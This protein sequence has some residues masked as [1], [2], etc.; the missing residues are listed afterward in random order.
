MCLRK[1]KEKKCKSL[2][3]FR[4]ANKSDNYQRGEEKEKNRKKSKRIYRTNQNIIHVFLE[5]VPSE[6]FYLLE[7]TVHLTCLGCS[8]TLY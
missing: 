4:S 6:S 5:S 2:I 1:K 8:R 3:R 7:V